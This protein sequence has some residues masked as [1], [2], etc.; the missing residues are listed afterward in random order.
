[1]L[2]AHMSSMLYIVSHDQEEHRPMTTQNLQT[3]ALENGFQADEASEVVKSFEAIEA[4]ADRLRS[5]L[6]AAGLQ[7]HLDDGAEF[8]AKESLNDILSDLR[9]EMKI[10]E[11]LAA[12]ESFE[13]RRRPINA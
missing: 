13:G 12:L 1:M 2:D 7:K 10:D 11:R 9:F 3:D 6:T 5:A 8:S 4:A